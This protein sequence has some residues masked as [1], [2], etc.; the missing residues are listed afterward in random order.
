METLNDYRDQGDPR[1]L[2]GQDVDK[3][4]WVFD[5]MKSAFTRK[6]GMSDIFQFRAA[7]AMDL[8]NEELDNW[9]NE[10]K[11]KHLWAADASLWTNSDEAEWLGWLNVST[12]E[13]EDVPRIEALAADIKAEG[14]LHIVV[15]GMGGSSLCPDMIA[16][17]F[18]DI[19]DSPRLQVLGSTDPN[20]IR[21]LENSSGPCLIK[22]P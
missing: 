5:Q 3:A 20:Q 8:I 17:I 18:T 19:Q 13:L 9:Q 6:N 2:L 16:K 7:S 22:M 1:L 21:H 15:L 14:Y 4:D 10:E 12:S 11:L